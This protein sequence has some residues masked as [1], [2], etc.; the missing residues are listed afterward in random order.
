[1]AT[2]DKYIDSELRERHASALHKKINRSAE[3]A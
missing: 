2:T 1:M 3:D